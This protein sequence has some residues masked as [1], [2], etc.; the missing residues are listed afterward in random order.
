MTPNETKHLLAVFKAT[1]T[2]LNRIGIEYILYG[3]TLI[4][5]YRHHAL[6]PWDDDVDILV[7]VYKKDQLREVFNNS[8]VVVD[9]FGLQLTEFRN[10][11]WKIF[12]SNVA[13]KMA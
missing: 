4:G 12:D 6:I 2:L 8:E 5:A 1:T 3:G 11:I 13:R 7:S 9:G 10:N